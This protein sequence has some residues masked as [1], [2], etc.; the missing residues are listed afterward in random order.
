MAVNA[1]KAS[2][3]VRATRNWPSVVDT[4]AAEPEAASGDAASTATETIRPETVALADCRGG[5]ELPEGEVGLPP[6]A[7]AS[8]PIA[9]SEAA[10]QA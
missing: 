6:H 5:A 8:P 2:C 4:I 9:M 1:E 3:P 10:W 7:L